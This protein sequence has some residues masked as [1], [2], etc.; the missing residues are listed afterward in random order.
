MSIQQNREGHSSNPNSTSLESPTEVK[1]TKC[2]T[3]SGL[4]QRVDLDYPFGGMVMRKM[5]LGRPGGLL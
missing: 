5:D 3:F 1:A 2:Y 4:D